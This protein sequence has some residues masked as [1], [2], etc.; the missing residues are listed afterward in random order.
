MLGVIIHGDA[1]LGGQGIVYESVNFEEL[2]DYGTGGVIHIV[3]N[4]HIGFTTQPKQDRTSYHCTEFAKIINAPVIH[5]NA[6]EPELVNQCIKIALDYRK[7]F[8]K[9]FFIDLVGYRR[10]GHN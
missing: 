4:N 5:V 3:F 7:K 6:D 9:D 8:K 2:E 1:A 10:Y